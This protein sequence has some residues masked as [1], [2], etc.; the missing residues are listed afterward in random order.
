M[1]KILIYEYIT[2][3]G[4]IN[5]DLSSN[6]LNEAKLM[7]SELYK[8]LKELKHISFKF[9]LDERL[10]IPARSSSIL[11][12]K[13]NFN[14]M[15]NLQILKEFDLILPI[16]PE[17]DLI[18]Y[19]YIKFLEKEKIKK[20]ISDGKTI[21]SLSDKLSFYQL[22]RKYNL[23]V[24]PTY[25]IKE[26]KLINKLKK[27]IVKDRYGVGCSYVKFYNKPQ[28]VKFSLY[29]NDYVVQPYIHG[30]PY[31]ISAFFT[32]NDFYLLT[33]NKQYIKF[34]KNNFVKL[35]KILVNDKGISDPK[36]YYLLSRIKSILPNLY[37][38]VGN[39]ILVVGE[40]LHVVEINPRLTT[41]YIGL[42]RT[43]NINL[44]DIIIGHKVK[45]RAIS[46]KKYCIEIN[47]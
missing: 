39:D 47:E 15:Y 34:T 26:T 22:L 19:N 30:E 25:D 20:V 21:F 1:L 18:L 10:E 4:L 29:N 31:S 32:F 11:I 36:V 37:G 16:L 35:K 13:R 27:I 9:L 46:G 14:D 44:F 6:L 5:E 38:Y 2:G 7:V 41:S 45:K 3:G 42:N 40:T 28:E 23:D 24:I 12:K 17:K 33:V 43:L 8:D